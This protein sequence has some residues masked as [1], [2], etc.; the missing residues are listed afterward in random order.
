VEKDPLL[1]GVEDTEVTVKIA[2]T[3]RHAGAVKAVDAA[4]VEDVAGVEVAEDKT[5]SSTSTTRPSLPWDRHPKRR[6][7]SA[8]YRSHGKSTQHII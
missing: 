2:E 3:G 1:P 4:V 7:P 6:R 8:H 5:A